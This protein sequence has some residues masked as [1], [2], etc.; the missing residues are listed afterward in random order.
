MCLEE[1]PCLVGGAVRWA[2]YGEF[3]WWPAL[4]C[5]QS[6]PEIVLRRHQEGTPTSASAVKRGAGNDQLWHFFF[7]DESYAWL[8][9]S[10][11][12]FVVPFYQRSRD[13]RIYAG[14]VAISP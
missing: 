6:G 2:R 1:H 8:S 9:R 11:Q 14:K 7:G 4:E 5:F 13:S 3:P 12:R 10:D